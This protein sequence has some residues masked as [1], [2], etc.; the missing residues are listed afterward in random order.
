[1]K[2]I[3]SIYQKTI[4]SIKSKLNF[5]FPIR[6][7]ENNNYTIVGKPEGGYE[8]LK[9]RTPEARNEKNFLDQNQKK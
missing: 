1:M 4:Q 8:S 6:R 5:S 3:Y 9:N 7:G 2:T